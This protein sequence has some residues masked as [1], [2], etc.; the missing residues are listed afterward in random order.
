MPVISISSFHASRMDASRNRAVNLRFGARE[1]NPNV[2]PT[3]YHPQKFISDGFSPHSHLVECTGCWE[4]K[5]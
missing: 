2:A 4:R 5:G 1:E 3:A